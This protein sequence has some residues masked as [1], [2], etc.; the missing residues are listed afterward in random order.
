M[1]Q[2]RCIV[3]RE[4]FNTED[5]RQI[6]NI[7]KHFN[8]DDATLEAKIGTWQ[9]IHNTD[10]LPSMEDLQQY[11]DSYGKQKSATDNIDTFSS[12]NNDIKYNK[13]EN[14]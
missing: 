4:L 8:W 1:S 7:Q 10:E 14:L 13:E 6:N 5:L 3:K 2:T 12:E 11:Q 9:T